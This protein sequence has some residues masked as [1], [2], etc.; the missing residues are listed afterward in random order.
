MRKTIAAAAVSLLAVAW[1][2]PAF[3]HCDTLDGPVVSAARK[4]LETGN[5]NH[6]LACT[7][8]AKGP[9]STA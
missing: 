8:R 2:A 5:V 4:A 7:V 3:A 9:P 6:A 1:T